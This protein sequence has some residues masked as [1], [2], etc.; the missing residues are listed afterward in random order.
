MLF[1]Q[2]LS[3]GTELSLERVWDKKVGV[4]NKKSLGGKEWIY[5]AALKRQFNYSKK[6]TI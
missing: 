3:T 5:K 2:N 1:L 6:I 4:K